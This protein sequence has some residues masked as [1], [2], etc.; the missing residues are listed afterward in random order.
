MPEDLITWK[1]KPVPWVTRWTEEMP[2]PSETVMHVEQAP[3]P[4]AV[5]LAYNTDYAAEER[6]AN[7]ILWQREGINR[8]GEPQFSQLSTYRQ[9][10]AM[11]KRLCQVCGQKIQTDVITWLMAPGQL[12]VT[13]EGY[14]VTT[15]PP[16][17]D[18]CVAIALEKCP[19]LL[20]A[21]HYVVKVLEYELWGVQGEGVLYDPEANAIMRQ[22]GLRVPYVGDLIPMLSRYAVVAKQ[23]VVR[24]TKFKVMD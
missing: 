24:F 2:D 8:G 10:A 21:G 17:C 4:G 16:T 19:H 6:E 12:D 1:G 23:Q 14:A 15:N 22:N 18:D 7:G 9:R 3:E 20:K 13:Q 5:M 11:R